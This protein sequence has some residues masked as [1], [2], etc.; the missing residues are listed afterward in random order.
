[1]ICNCNKELKFIHS[2][3]AMAK[4][5]GRQEEREKVSKRVVS[6]LKKYESENDSYRPFSWLRIDIKNLLTTLTITK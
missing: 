1:M 2:L 6:I 5:E 3:T 4:E